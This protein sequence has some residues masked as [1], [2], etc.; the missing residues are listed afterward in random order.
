MMHDSWFYYFILFLGA[1]KPLWT[2]T[3]GMKLK[4]LSSWDKSYDE[5]RQCIKKQRHHFATNVNIVKIMVFPAAMYRCNSQTIKK[6]ET[7]ELILLNCGAEEDSWEPLRLQGGQTVNPKGY[8][9]WIFIGRTD[10]KAPIFG[11]LLWRTDSLEKTLMLGKFEGKKRRGWQRMRWLDSITNSMDI[12]LSKLQEILKD[13]K[14]WHAI[15]H[16]VTKSQT[17]LSD[18]TRND[19]CNVLLN[20]IC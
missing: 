7:K 5:P 3:A 14:A 15:I 2:V 6:A 10:A 9:H 12:N 20:L 13:R 16:G 18:W 1:P 8:Q 4:M 11:Y 17:W 19:T